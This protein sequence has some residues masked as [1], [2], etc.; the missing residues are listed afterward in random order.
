[1]KFYDVLKG[2]FLVNKGAFK[3]WRIILF[4]VSLLLFM[5]SSS[6]SADRKVMEISRM[7]IEM[8]KLKALYIDSGTYLTRMKME[9]SVVKK[10]KERGLGSPTRPPIK[11]KVTVK[12]N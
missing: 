9:S 2:G 4:V 8:R 12:T 3:N 6:H 11:I 5:I 7:N 10:L 1:M